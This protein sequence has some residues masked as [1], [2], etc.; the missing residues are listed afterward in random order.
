[1]IPR[2]AGESM[3]GALCYR[4]Y[5]NPRLPDREKHV[6]LRTKAKQNSRNG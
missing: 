4:D 6:S 2:R 5:G 1:M 3:V